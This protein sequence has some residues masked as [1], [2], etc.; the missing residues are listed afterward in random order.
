MSFRRQFNDEKCSSSPHLPRVWH[1]LGL[2]EG[3]SEHV[4]VQ[5]D[6]KFAE[7]VAAELPILPADT[8]TRSQI[9]GKT[10]LRN[11]PFLTRL[12]CESDCSLR[13]GQCCWTSS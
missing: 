8:A 10:Q 7:L 9:L 3:E 1:V 11:R 13:A 4:F 12:L 6:P 2:F 5:I